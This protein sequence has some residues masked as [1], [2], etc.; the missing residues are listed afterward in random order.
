MKVVQLQ[1]QALTNGHKLR[2]F[3]YISDIMWHCHSVALPGLYA[4]TIFCI[5]LME[6]HQHNV[7]CRIYAIN[8][9]MRFQVLETRR[10]NSRLSLL[11][12]ILRG[13][14]ATDAEAYLRRIHTRTGRMNSVK[15][16]R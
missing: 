1:P 12:K 15:L 3:L 7:Q 4:C 14:V 13:R 10:A 11:D 5:L 6:W 2:Y 16:R 8:A 9:G